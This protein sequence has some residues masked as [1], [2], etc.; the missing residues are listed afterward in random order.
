M[1]WLDS[2]RPNDP[3]PEWGIYIILGYDVNDAG[4]PMML[5]V[6]SI[7]HGA[8]VRSFDSS[9]PSLT[10]TQSPPCARNK[11]NK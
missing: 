10:I 8:K 6:N 9:F 7:T 1:Q 11:R 3:D 2:T 4:K 5:F